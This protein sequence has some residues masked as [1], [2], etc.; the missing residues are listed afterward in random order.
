MTRSFLFRWP[1]ILAFMVGIGT[2]L[3]AQSLI[4]Y[5][6][7]ANFYAGDANSD[8]D[9]LDNGCDD[10]VAE[11]QNQVEKCLVDSKNLEE[12]QGCSQM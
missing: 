6:H 12:A 2:S 8:D 9:R 10:D 5:A 7:A 3:G 4:H 1:V 11:F